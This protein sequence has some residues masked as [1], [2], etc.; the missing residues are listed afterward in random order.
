MDSQTQYCLMRR[1]LEERVWRLTSRVPELTSELIMQIGPLSDMHPRW[2]R[3]HLRLQSSSC[4]SCLGRR[5]IT[6]TSNLRMLRPGVLAPL[7]PKTTY[8]CFIFPKTRHMR[9]Q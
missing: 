1:D 2:T 7:P 8:S 6:S 9:K 4:A 3:G 5:Q